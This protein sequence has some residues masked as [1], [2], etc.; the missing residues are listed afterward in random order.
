MHVFNKVVSGISMTMFSSSDV[1]RHPFVARPLSK[2]YA[3]V[4]DI[5]EEA[6]KTSAHPSSPCCAA[7]HSSKRKASSVEN[8][9]AH[10]DFDFKDMKEATHAFCPAE[11]EYQEF[12]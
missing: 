6:E 8:K 1:V 9:L 5:E 3:F 10:L 4:F 2:A 7:E 11:A 12:G